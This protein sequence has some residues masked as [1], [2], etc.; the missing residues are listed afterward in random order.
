[1]PTTTLEDIVRSGRSD[2]LALALQLLGAAT[3]LAERAGA[4]RSQIDHIRSLAK[5]IKR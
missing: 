2:D 4:D 5:R 3:M 1:M